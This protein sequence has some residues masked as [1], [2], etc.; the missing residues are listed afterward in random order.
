M[1][2]I[3]PLRKYQKR[4]NSVKTTSHTLLTFL[5]VRVFKE[6]TKSFNLFFLFLCCIVMIPGFT[7]FSGIT[8]IICICS[9]ISINIV[10]TAV[11]EI[12]KYQL[13]Q[14]INR[15]PFTLLRNGA[16]QQVPREHINIGDIIIVKE[17]VLLPTNILLIGIFNGTGDKTHAYVETSSLNGES[18]LLCKYPLLSLGETGEITDNDLRRIEDIK[19]IEKTKNNGLLYMEEEE[20]SF[21][22]ENLVLKGCSFY[23]EYEAVGVSLGGKNE[24][25]ERRIK[26]SLFMLIISEKTIL[27][28]FIYLFLL[29]LSS[30]SSC[31]FI[32][33]STW[34]SSA[35]PNR[36]YP[37][38]AIKSFAANIVIFSNLIPLSLFVTLDGLRIAYAIY[39]K[40]DKKMMK[41]GKS[42]E[43][44]SYGIVEDIGLVSH[45]LTDKTGTL[46]MNQMLLK[47]I[48]LRGAS[49]PFF[50]TDNSFEDLLSQE[51]SGIFLLA[52]LLCH[53][54]EVVGSEYQGVSQEEISV[55]SFLSEKGI[56][57][58]ERKKNFIS[59]SVNKKHI[60][61]KILHTLP[62][63]SSLSRM[64]VIAEVSG[65]CFLL[66]KGSSEVVNSSGSLQVDGKYRALTVAVK[67]LNPE[68]LHNTSQYIAEQNIPISQN[69]Y[70]SLN[71]LPNTSLSQYTP[72]NSV[73]LIKQLEPLA[74]YVGTLYIE[75]ILQE[76]ADQVVNEL[77]KNGINVWMVTGDRKE[78]AISCAS[79]TNILKPSSEILSGKD[80][81]KIL[82]QEIEKENFASLKNNGLIIYRCSPEEKKQITQ[83][84]REEGAVV[85]AVGDGENDIGMIEEADIGICVRGKEGKKAA[86]I[87]DIII[88]SFSSLSQLVT[89]HGKVC[90]QRLKAVYFFYVFKCTAGAI[91]QSLYGVL[92]GS[93]GSIAFSSLFLIF[94]N[95][96]ITSPLSV[97][98]G[99][100]RRKST[101]K[102]IEE[103]ILAGAL[104]GVFSFLVVYIGFSSVDAIDY[105]GNLANS[106]I[107]SRIFSLCLYIST[108]FHFLWN[109]DEYTIFSVVT[110][111]MSAFFFLAAIGVDGGFNIFLYPSMYLISLFMV[112]SSIA[113]ERF[114]SLVK[115]PEHYPPDLTIC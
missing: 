109:A 41:N 79:S 36:S 87:S 110:V 50:L 12:K 66:I 21:T 61:C 32:H 10:K 14:E 48:H 108:I 3:R 98:I 102:S 59:F 33:N 92:V 70:F 27:V 71:N 115:R 65:K 29:L 88:P 2:T 74:E 4:T 112:T 72:P 103:A 11:E 76:H 62:F 42:C 22:E 73:E 5:P 93:S 114:V 111:L 54:V 9:V 25:E 46:T 100:F 84:L 26:N 75:D 37:S 20:K 95:S 106:H 86:F 8:Y 31:Y 57:L 30:I 49:S 15:Q 39:L 44:N 101:V 96:L 24:T 56:S 13:D 28:I 90:L 23:G 91:C 80:I 89:Y 81:I 104:Y 68:Y 45:V 85:L 1:E 78:S 52:A 6:F 47:A 53:S 99:L 67:E 69:I 18:A 35:Y 38:I 34:I 105:N 51:Y 107:I 82:H 16:L 58:I 113:I 64:A 97:E 60:Y 7:P 19:K 43:S 40:N 83:L 55:L 63:S 94:Y 77:M 17:K